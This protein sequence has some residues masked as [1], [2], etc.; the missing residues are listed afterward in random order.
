MGRRQLEAE[1]EEGSWLTE[2]ALAADVFTGD[3][4]GCGPRWSGARV[5]SSG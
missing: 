2:P 5:R 3:P 1:L 4:E